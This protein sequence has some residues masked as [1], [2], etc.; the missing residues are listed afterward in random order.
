MNGADRLCDTLLANGV[1]VCFAN[2]GTSEMHFVAALDE[3]SEM[4]CVLGLF[5]GVVTGAADGYA[6]MTDRPAATLL[7]LGPGLAN[8]L[9]NLHN[10]KRARTPMINVVGDHATYFLQHDAPL[11]SDIDSLARPMC[12]WL[13]RVERASDVQRATEEAYRAAMRMPGVA[14][15][16]LPADAAWGDLACAHAPTPLVLPELP[17]VDPSRVREAAACLRSGAR[18]ALL[19]TGSALRA[20]PLET[21][22]RIRDATGARL[23]MQTS[24]SRVERGAGRVG[25]SPIPY[26]VDSAVAALADVDAVIVLGAKVPVA[27]FAYPGKPSAL[28][29]PG[30]E[31][32]EL[33]GHDVDLA[34][35]LEK[36]AGELGLPA[37]R[38]PAIVQGSATAEFTTLR[39]DLTADAVAWITARA[40]PDAAIVADETISAG[41]SF[42]EHS[43]TSAPHDYLRITGG[44]IGIGIPLAT[45]AAIACPDRKVVALQADGSGMYTIQGLWTQ[46]RERLDV[47]TIVFANRTY[48]ILHGEMAKVGVEQFGHNAARMLNIDDPALDWVSMANGMGVEA[49]RADTPERFFELLGAALARRGPFLIEARV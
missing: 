25:I 10:A 41:S 23:L 37:S 18:A 35:A 30:C 22:G 8:G 20:R 33:A 46:A 36:L 3:R 19:M 39:G 45:G 43:R 42:F 34:D 32:I 15:L 6:R 26:A 38:R 12:G 40:L 9:A 1:N 47:L 16:I 29:R 5:E 49:A 4:R 13:S 31:I 14:T 44:A 17:S 21:A 7:H 27:F 24:N 28:L 48:G 11:A 2:P